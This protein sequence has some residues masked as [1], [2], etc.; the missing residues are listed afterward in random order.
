MKEVCELVIG[1]IEGKAKL[2]IGLADFIFEL[3]RYIPWDV[4]RV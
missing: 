3:F 1:E 4:D 2:L